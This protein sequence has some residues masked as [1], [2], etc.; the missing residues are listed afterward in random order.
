MNTLGAEVWISSNATTC[1]ERCSSPF[2]N[3]VPGIAIIDGSC[4]A[5]GDDTELK[6]FD[7]TASTRTTIPECAT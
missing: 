5:F 1:V 6:T 3:V 4:I 2:G 7:T